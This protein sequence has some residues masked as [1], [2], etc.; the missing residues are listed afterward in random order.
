MFGVSLSF[1]VCQAILVVFWVDMPNL[2][3]SALATLAPIPRGHQ[4]ISQ[5]IGQHGDDYRLQRAAVAIILLVWP[6][7]ILE[8]IWHWASRPWDRTTRKFH[9]FSLLFCL[10]PSLRMCA[11][12]PEMHERM[13]LPILSWRQPNRRLQ[14]RLQRRLSL[15]MIGIS[16]LIMPVLIVEFFLQAQVAQYAWLRTCLHFGTGVIWFA[17]AFEFILMVSIAR[18]KLDYCRRHWVDIAII[19]LPL[20]S[21]L[22]SLQLV[23]STSL[24]RLPMLTRLARVYRLRGTAI[25]VFN[26]LLVLEFFHR[27]LSRD[28]ERRIA[29]LQEQLAEAEWQAKELRRKIA[30]LERRKAADRSK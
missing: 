7:V 27:A 16:L 17:F 1:L 18:K 25:K 14:Q 20:L 12:S 22:R 9:L 13:W 3:E 8:S 26:G 21:M 4:R 6:L 23:R 11:R 15:P 29:R 2:S 28:P 30:R 24:L 19:V 10:C 5:L